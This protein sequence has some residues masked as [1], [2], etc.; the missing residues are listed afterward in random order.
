MPVLT[1][2]KNFLENI[3]FCETAFLRR[4][5]GAKRPKQSYI[6][7]Y[8]LRLL[9]P[10]LAGSQ[11]RWREIASA[12]CQVCRNPEPRM[13]PRNEGIR[14]YAKSAEIL[15]RTYSHETKGFVTHFVRS[16]QRWYKSPF[17]RTPLRTEKRVSQK[18][19]VKNRFKNHIYLLTGV[20]YNKC[21]I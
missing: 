6:L 20:V 17:C 21:V 16:S 8:L 15:S 2:H 13:F 4:C 1:F 19:L 12:L 10:P 3:E 11:R 5:E 7:L 18:S 14:P 9:H